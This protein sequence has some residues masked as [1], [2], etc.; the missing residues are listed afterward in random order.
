MERALKDDST[1]DQSKS[2]KVAS[3]HSV[4]IEGSRQLDFLIRYAWRDGAVAAMTTY[5]S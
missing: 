5:L 4:R 1:D 3:D 2:S